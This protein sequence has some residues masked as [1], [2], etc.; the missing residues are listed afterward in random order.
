M[1]LKVVEGVP[2]DMYELLRIYEFGNCARPSAQ[3]TEG[4]TAATPEPPRGVPTPSERALLR[5]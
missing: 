5:A 3:P 4:L 2:D 1:G